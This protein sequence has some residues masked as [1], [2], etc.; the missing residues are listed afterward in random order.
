MGKILGDQ[1]SVMLTPAFQNLY[2]PYILSC[3]KMEKAWKCLNHWFNVSAA[4]DLYLSTGLYSVHNLNAIVTGKRGR[5]LFCLGRTSLWK[6][7]G[8][9]DMT[10]QL[11]NIYRFPFLAWFCFVFIVEGFWRKGHYMEWGAWKLLSIYGWV[12]EIA[13]KKEM[14][15]TVSRRNPVDM[16]CFLI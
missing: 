3:L 1:M 14:Q 8:D 5:N 12:V 11:L 7:L 16:E 6:A 9:W 10:P 13:W 4:S 2:A 15:H